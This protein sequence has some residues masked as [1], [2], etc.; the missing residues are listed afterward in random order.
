M[1][2]S[3]DEVREATC[4]KWVNQGPEAIK[5]LHCSIQLSMKFILLINLKILT[6]ANMVL[7]NIAE[8]EIFSAN[9]YENVI[10]SLYEH[11]NK[12]ASQAPC[13]ATATYSLCTSVV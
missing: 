6:I 13:P 7:L 11:E 8:C 2:L 10:N 5:R 12:T 4:H 1:D 3:E 9:K